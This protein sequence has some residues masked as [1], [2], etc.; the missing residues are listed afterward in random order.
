MGLTAMATLVLLVP[1]R[2]EKGSAE[3]FFNEGFL[4]GSHE[5]CRWQLWPWNPRTAVSHALLGTLGSPGSAGTW[6]WPCSYLST[7][8]Q[9]LPLFLHIASL[10]RFSMWSLWEDSRLITYHLKAQW[11]IKAEARCLLWASLQNWRHVTS[12]TDP[13]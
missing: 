10:G 1:P 5:V 7:R 13:Q 3:W 12:A 8:F 11:T 9:D 2:V 4:L 6:G